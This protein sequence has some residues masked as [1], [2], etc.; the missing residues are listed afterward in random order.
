MT[1]TIKSKSK[2]ALQELRGKLKNTGFAVIIESDNE[3]T[4]PE[5]GI[6]SHNYIKKVAKNLNIKSFRKYFNDLDLSKKT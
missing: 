2:S 3:I 6:K 1:L 4:I 5:I